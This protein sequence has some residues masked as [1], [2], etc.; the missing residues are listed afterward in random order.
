M[1]THFQRNFRFLHIFKGEK[2]EITP[3]IK[4]IYISPH[5]SCGGIWNYSTCG[6]ISDFSTSVIYRNLKFL[7]MTNFFS[8][9]I[10]VGSVT[11]MRYGSYTR[12][13]TDLGGNRTLPD[14]DYSNIPGHVLLCF[15]VCDEF[16]F[17]ANWRSNDLKRESG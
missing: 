16:Q 12:I 13:L 6:E 10:S 8:T 2:S 1:W 17:R 7:H 5:L 15:R 3:H 9:D 14:S 11:N 4:K